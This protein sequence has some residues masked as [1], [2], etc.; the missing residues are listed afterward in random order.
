MSA[1][2]LTTPS[3][4]NRIIAGH[5]TYRTLKGHAMTGQNETPEDIADDTEGHSAKAFSLGDDLEGYSA[6]ARFGID[7]VEGH[8]ASGR[9]GID[10]VEGHLGSGRFETDD[11][12]GHG[13]S[14]RFGIDDVEGHG[15]SGRLSTEDVEGHNAKVFKGDDADDDT[16]DD[17][18]GH[19][20]K[21]G[22]AGQPAPWPDRMP[23]PAWRVIVL[24][25]SWRGKRLTYSSRAGTRSS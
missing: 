7:D 25:W 9:F 10:D 18:E 3:G 13:A 1:S 2:R 6:G 21:I 14:G 17:A 19:A 15:V 16:P 24:A 4:S 23:V 12:E 11:V 8:S 22:L 20:F 5:M